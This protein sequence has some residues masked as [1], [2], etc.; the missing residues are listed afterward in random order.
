[1][2][3]F[4][5]TITDE[6]GIH[7][8]PAGLLVKEAAKQ[9]CSVYIVKGEKRADAKKIFNVMGLAVKCG[10][11]IYVECEGEQEEEAVKTLQTFCK[12]N[13]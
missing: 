6:L 12:S 2:I 8:R 3:S 7:A 5:Y 1:M 4:E 9:E 13:L 10:D 11:K